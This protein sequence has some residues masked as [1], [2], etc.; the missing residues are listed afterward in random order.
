MGD[1]EKVTKEQHDAQ[2]WK[3]VLEAVKSVRY[4]SVTIIIQDGRVVQIDKCEK[5][6]LVKGF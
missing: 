6:R 3:R 1:V 2:V 4:G 5:I